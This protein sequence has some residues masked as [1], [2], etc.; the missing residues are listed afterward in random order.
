MVVVGKLVV[1]A[2][3]KNKDKFILCMQQSMEI[4]Q[5]DRQIPEAYHLISNH[6]NLLPKYPYVPPS[7][8][9]RLG[10][11]KLESFVA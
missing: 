1:G 4:M 11:E 5:D 8:W 6:E 7:C 9:A 3:S 10:Q 2:Y